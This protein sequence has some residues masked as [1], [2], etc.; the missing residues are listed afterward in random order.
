MSAGVKWNE[1][2][3][4]DLSAGLVV[5]LVATPLCL[6]IALASGAPFFSGLL[7]GMVGGLIVPLISR[8]E[9]S[10]SGPAAGLTAVVAMGISAVGSFEALLTALLIAGALQ[11][12]LGLLKAGLIAYFFPNA[13]IKGMLSAIGI[14]LLLKQLP[15][16]VGYD[17]E[18][19]ANIDFQSGGQENTF[20]LFWHALENIEWG[21][22][23]I[24]SLS[25]LVLLAWPYTP[26]ERLKWMPGALGVVII[27]ILLNQAFGQWVPELYLGPAHLVSLPPILHPADFL[28]GITFPNL[29]AIYESS[30]WVTGITIGLV[31]S[32]ETLLTIEAVDKL[33][34]W[35][36]HSPLN[37]ELLA[38]GTG[39]LLC[40]MLGGIPITSVIVRSSAGINAGGRTRMMSFFHGLFLLLAVLFASRMLNLIPMASLA[41]ILLQ[42]GYKLATPAIFKNAWQK[43]TTQ[44]VP[45]IITVLAILLTNLLLGVAIGLVTGIV[46]IVWGGL[47]QVL[48]ISKENTQFLVTFNRDI[49][50]LSKAKVMR[51]LEKMPAGANIIIDARNARYIDQDILEVI[52]EFRH[53]SVRRG[54]SVEFRNFPPAHQ[55]PAATYPFS[56]L[57]P[58]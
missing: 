33:D 58:E 12:L 7:A 54:I 53:D 10:V 9:L 57:L 47:N 56:L 23:V 32:I 46:F 52:G 22:V 48:S 27:G 28:R 5:F 45:F 8:A 2:A 3:M 34:P 21:A 4:A 16:A 1:S 38:Q 50:F 40:G 6:G 15:H 39:N 14:I 31:A 55:V 26:L 24:S 25:L 20:S 44:F 29:N 11:L 49:T 36:R 18:N 17:L 41:A 43:G 42:V 35:R 37:R 13:V 51:A 30:V 19:F